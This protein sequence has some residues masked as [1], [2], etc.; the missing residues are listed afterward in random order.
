MGQIID[1]NIEI[2]D[3]GIL[4]KWSTKQASLQMKQHFCL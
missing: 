3:N 1:Y 4:Q 2:I